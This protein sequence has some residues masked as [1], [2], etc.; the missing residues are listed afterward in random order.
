MIIDALRALPTSAA[1]HS[2]WLRFGCVPLL[3]SET[4]ARSNGI[5]SSQ[6][7]MEILDNCGDETLAEGDMDGV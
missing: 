1:L 3:Q 7:A 2:P 5:G 4:K 6:S